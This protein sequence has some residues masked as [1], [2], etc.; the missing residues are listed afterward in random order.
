[1][2]TEE[3]ENALRSALTRAAADIPDAEQARQR[4]MQRNYR[5][6]GGRRKLAAGIAATTAAAAVVL[7][8]GLSGV[9]GPAPARGT[10]TIRTTAFTLVKHANGTVTLA[11]NLNV[12][13]E[14]SILQRD[15]RQDGITAIVTSGSFCSSDPSPAGFS[16][17]MPGPKH[18]D[19]V[20]INPAAIS[21]GTE[22]SF[23]YFQTSSLQETA[24]GLIYTSSHTCTSTTPTAPPSG[25]DVMLV[26]ASPGATGPALPSSSPEPSRSRP[27]R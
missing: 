6:R 2:P 27:Q 12:L 23:G 24:M 10:G 11:S 17:V 15:L 22:L 16:R 18:S 8:L 13:L 9:V 25:S 5:P 21:S 3:L 4:L 19:A 1:M 26:H 14:P 20:T 7:G